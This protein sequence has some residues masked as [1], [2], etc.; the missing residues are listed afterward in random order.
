MANKPQINYL[1]RD[2]EA[3]KDELLEYAKRFYPN[4]Y[5]D[6]S[7]ASFGS[8]LLDAVAYIG[9]VSSFQLDYQSNENLLTTAVNRANIV[10]LA[11][12]M[13][14]NDPL[15]P[16][17][18]GVVSLYLS[19]PAG[20]DGSPDRSYL[21]VLKRG[22][23]FSS[24]AGATYTLIE[25]VDFSAAGVEFVVSQVN[26][27]TGVPTN[28]AAKTSGI[29]AS[30]IIKSVKINVPDQGSST[31]FYS[32]TIDDE[33]VVEVISVFDTEGN[34]YYEVEALSQDVVLKGLPNQNSTASNT[35]NILKPTVAARRFIVRFQDNAVNLIFGN[36][37]EDTNST[38]DSVNDP[39]KVVL[40]KFGKDYVTKTIL[41]PTVLKANDKFGIGP[42]NTVI[43]VR[44]RANTS[45]IIS[46]Q[47]FS[48]VFVDDSVFEFST[49]ATNE[50]LKTNVRS[51]LEVENPDDIQGS[52]N[53][54]TNEE[55]K[56]LA[57]GVFSSQGRVVTAQ[58]YVN[59]SYRMPAQFGAIKRAAAI[60]DDFSPRRG[61]NL[62]VLG[63][64]DTGDLVV[65]SQAIKDNLKT[66]LTQ[67]KPISDSVDILDGR[68]I[69]FGLRISMVSNVAYS[70]VETI[71]AAQ[72]VAREYFE[73][74][75]YNF[76]ESI[77]VSELTRILN[78]T[79]QVTDILKMEF[80]SL[81]GGSFSDVEYDFIRNTTSDGRFITI[82]EDYVFEIK[83]FST[84]IT[85]EAV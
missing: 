34:E 13:G 43:T 23:A 31:D 39:T 11:R 27:S 81:T 50:T 57:L 67:Y 76:G 5:K 80:Y 30:G 18:T 4:Q 51:S 53:I 20:A 9:D 75:K 83:L 72:Q 62:Y 68:I 69:N 84:S 37:K 77:N 73:R 22:T 7:D 24:E 19:I 56:E 78:D 45:N 66:W 6:F 17:I 42:S 1:A 60:R 64:D 38:I 28:Y 15:S 44:Y 29:V 21:P 79:E 58:D 61:I 52:R 48:L 16:N 46:A 70:T 54:L 12:Q 47:Q 59:F 40:Q 8:F 32:T 36:G 49:D 74:R 33:N 3:I 41:D 2:F 26:D 63:E 55:I 14:Y 82:P 65:A 25:D 35:I 85:A 10:N 71:A